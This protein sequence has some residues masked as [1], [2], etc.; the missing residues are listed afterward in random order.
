MEALDQVVLKAITD[1]LDDRLIEQAID[2][3]LQR[4][5]SGVDHRLDREPAIKRELDLLDAKQ[6]KIIDAIER[7]EPGKPLGTRLRETESRKE[8]LIQELESF[9]TQTKKVA[10]LD[11]ARI[12][13]QLRERAAD[14][15]GLLERNTP[16]ARQILRKLLEGKLNCTPVREEGSK[17]YQ[18]SGKGS[19]QRLLPASLVLPTKVASPTGFEPVLSA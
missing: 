18:V 11:G 16:Q 12:K 7:G 10:T 8:E 4:M 2:T 13:R 1:V 19:S 3:A 15:K 14:V 17:G 5:R 6:Q 9:Q